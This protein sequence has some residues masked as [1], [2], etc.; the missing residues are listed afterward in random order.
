MVR[1]ILQFMAEAHGLK[2]PG[3]RYQRYSNYI[4][5]TD[6]WEYQLWATR[7]DAVERAIIATQKQRGRRGSLAVGLKNLPGS[8]PD[9]AG[10]QVKWFCRNLSGTPLKLNFIDRRSI[11]KRTVPRYDSLKLGQVYLHSERIPILNRWT[12]A[13]GESTS[14]IRFNLYIPR[15]VSPRGTNVYGDHIVVEQPVRDHF[16]QRNGWRVWV[17]KLYNPDKPRSKL[18]RLVDLEEEKTLQDLYYL[19]GFLGGSVVSQF[20]FLINWCVDSSGVRLPG[21]D[22]NGI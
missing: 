17:S 3:D 1:D 15:A 5:P 11:G 21:I 4:P 12:V 19:D 8:P 13:P 2:V 20:P 18:G 7:E 6:T 16:M 9:D 10:D 22:H 14:V